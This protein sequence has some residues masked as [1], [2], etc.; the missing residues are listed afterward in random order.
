MYNKVRSE[1]AGVAP[2][3]EVASSPLGKV[4]TKYCLCVLCCCSTPPLLLLLLLLLYH[5][6]LLIQQL[7]DLVVVVTQAAF[8]ADAAGLRLDTEHT[9]AKGHVGSLHHIYLHF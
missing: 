4:L 9:D 7:P 2:E 1:T 3:A 8:Q 5:G 6:V